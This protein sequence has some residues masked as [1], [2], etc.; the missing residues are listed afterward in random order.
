MSVANCPH[1]GSPALSDSELG[2]VIKRLE[3]ENEKEKRE[4][5]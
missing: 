4:V 3:Y 1:C 5:E 2:E